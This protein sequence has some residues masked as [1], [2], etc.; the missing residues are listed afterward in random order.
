MIILTGGLGFIGSNILKGLNDIGYE[1]II[2]CDW[3]EKIG[4]KNINKHNFTQIISP[5][6]LFSFLKKNKNIEFII[7]MGAISSTTENNFKLI[8]NNNTVYSRNIWNWCVKN[9]IKFIYASSAAT[10]GDG[11]LGFSDSKNNI[12]KPL[13]Y[14]GWSKYFFD[15]YVIKQV[16]NEKSPP[17]WVGLKFFNVYGPNE[18]HKGNMQSVVKHSLD[19]IKTN[20][21]VNLFKS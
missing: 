17:Q 7:H 8:Y 14:Y 10:Y 15:K 19:Q 4:I 13:N 20:G 11:S 2:I 5:D 1:N 3:V 18:Y 16:R 9:K 12:F 6:D 21:Y